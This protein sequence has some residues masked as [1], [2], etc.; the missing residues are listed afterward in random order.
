MSHHPKGYP[1]RVPADESVTRKARLMEKL[2]RPQVS[3]RLC[4]PDAEA[5]GELIATSSIARHTLYFA[6]TLVSPYMELAP[7]MFHTLLSLLFS[8]LLSR[9]M[10][11]SVSACE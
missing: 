3:A 2:V 8:L 1:L 4:L 7:L 11:R 10:L 6:I 5:I 9:A